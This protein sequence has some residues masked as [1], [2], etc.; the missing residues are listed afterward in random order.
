MA[1]MAIAIHAGTMANCIRFTLKMTIICGAKNTRLV[2]NFAQSLV[3]GCFTQTITFRG[4]AMK[5][6]PGP[7]KRGSR[8]L[9]IVGSKPVTLIATI[10]CPSEHP[11]TEAKAHANS[12]LIAA[13]PEMLEALKELVAEF[14]SRNEEFEDIRPGYFKDTGGIAYARIIIAK[15][16]GR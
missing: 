8:I 1:I 5:H 12:N 6:T 16:E 13:A 15:A 7:W 11:A 4:G 14:D 9:D 10:A 3:C 2:A